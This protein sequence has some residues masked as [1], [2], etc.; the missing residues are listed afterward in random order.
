[1]SCKKPGWKS[2]LFAS[3]FMGIAV[4]IFG[5]YMTTNLTGYSVSGGKGTIRVTGE[6]DQLGVYNNGLFLGNTP[7]QYNLPAGKQTITIKKEGFKD[8]DINVNLKAGFYTPVYAEPTIICYDSDMGINEW[9]RASIDSYKELGNG[10]AYQKYKVT[11]NC[12]DSQSLIEYY[13]AKQK[14]ES[15]TISCKGGCDQGRCY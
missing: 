3:V 5:L 8:L 6:P 15:R 10:P 2:F 7:L 11:D 9:V 12:F 4:F 14:V 13:C 1:M